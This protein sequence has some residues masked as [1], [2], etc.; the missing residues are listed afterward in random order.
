M[1]RTVCGSCAALLLILGAFYLPLPAADQ[2]PPT[3]FVFRD[4]GNEWGLFPD[5]AGIA[6]HGVGWGD[7]D[8]SGY[9]SLYVGTFGGAPYGSKPN[10]F[11]RN[12]KGRFQLDDQKHLRIMGRAS[13]AVFADFDNDGHLDLY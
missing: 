6:G 5:V 1:K 12:I 2:T 4:V 13:S 8:G 11:F 9:P 10:Q 3:A 7:V